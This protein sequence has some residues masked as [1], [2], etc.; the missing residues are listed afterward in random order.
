[1]NNNLIFDGADIN[2]K[3]VVN[4]SPGK[5][6]E[7][8][9]IGDLHGNAVKFLYFLVREGVIAIDDAVYDQ[10]VDIYNTPVAQLTGND[11]NNMMRLI[12]DATVASTPKIRLIGDELADRGNNDLFTLLLMEKLHGNGVPVEI[13]ISNHSME[14]ITALEQM[15]KDQ[16]NDM[17]VQNYKG[18]WKQFALSLHNMIEIMDK[19][20]TPDDN[21]RDR[22]MKITNDIYRPSLNLISYDADR[23]NNVI[24][25]STHAPVS[26]DA[27]K[28]AAEYLN[29]VVGADIKYDDSSVGKLTDTIDDI[30]ACVM[31]LANQNN[32]AKHIPFDENKETA[33]SYIVWNRN[34]VSRP[35]AKNE[36]QIYYTHGHD[37]DASLFP[38]DQ[39]AHTYNLDSD[40][41]KGLM[42]TGEYKVLATS[43]F[44]MTMSSTLSS[45]VSRSFIREGVSEQGKIRERPNDPDHPIAVDVKKPRA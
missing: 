45:K 26:F 2:Y 27:I 25:L 42:S 7:C 34:P 41:G 40:L 23:E 22:I 44:D 29:N 15:H 11:I 30:N 24:A 28:N 6:G 3:P 39:T 38:T 14:Y 20:P 12:D 4:E 10:F 43:N 5:E 1:M 35:T 9:S 16:T 8:L 17:S 19:L 21:L 36:Y 31:D 32:L 33:L 13:N 18:G 37:K